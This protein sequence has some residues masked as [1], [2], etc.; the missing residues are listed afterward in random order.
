LAEGT[1]E[2][3]RECV[4]LL[5]RVSA[6]RIRD[7]LFQLLA[8]GNADR[9]LAEVL[10]AGTGPWLVGAEEAPFAASPARLGEVLSRLNARTP[11]RLNALL[12]SEPTTGRRRREVLLWAAALQPL[13]VEPAGA[14]R[15]LALSNDE[16]QIIVKALA[17]APGAAELA[18]R[19]P[20]AGRERYRLFK[21]AGSA[22][23]EAVL[24]APG[25]WKPA[26]DELLAAAVEHHFSPPQPL[27]TGHEV[28]K[29]LRLKPGPDLGRVLEELAEAQADGLVGT[30]EAARQWLQ[31]GRTA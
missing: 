22:E 6:E 29:L 14:C 16:K 4:P 15:K 23:P 13:G 24:L 17:A 12:S 31:E 8:L 25:Q 20:V 27:L 3:I 10:D 30:P 26:H 21:R 5:H 19:W 11:E 2:R 28:M 18:A 7:E 9:A 1:L